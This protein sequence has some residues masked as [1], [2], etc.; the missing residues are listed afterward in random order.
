MVGCAALE[1]LPFLC[2]TNRIST[3]IAMSTAQTPPT[4]TPAIAP[5]DIECD[6]CV[7]RV[8]VLDDELEVFSGPADTAGVGRT[9]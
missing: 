9:V 5:P 3:P 7:G 8:V 6:L 4:E 2:R 1:S